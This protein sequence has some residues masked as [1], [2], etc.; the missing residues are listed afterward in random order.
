LLGFDAIPIND[1]NGFY[2]FND[3]NNGNIVPVSKDQVRFIFNGPGAAKIFNNPF[4]N[5]P[6]NSEIGPKL[7]QVNAGLFKTTRLTERVSLQFRTEVFNLFNHP[8]PGVGLAS[9][10]TAPAVPTTTIESASITGGAFHE[11]RDIEYGRRIVQFGLK[12]IF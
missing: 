12:L 5:V 9:S 3:L 6:R 8:N 1:P 7:N 4:G 2:S 11:N 10:V